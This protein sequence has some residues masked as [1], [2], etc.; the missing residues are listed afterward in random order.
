MK[1][2]VTL[3]SLIKAKNDLEMYIKIDQIK[4]L[5][6]LFDPTFDIKDLNSKIDRYENQL[7]IIK[8]AIAI[9]NAVNKDESGNTLYY[10]IY[11][12]SKYNRLKS[13]LLTLQT[14]LDTDQFIS[15][16]ED[17]KKNLLHEIEQLDIDIKKETDKKVKAGYLSTKSKLKRSLS[18][19]SLTSKTHT[20]KL[21]DI[22]SE[23]LKAVETIII[24]IKNTLSKNNDAVSI[25]VDIT[26]EFELV[27]K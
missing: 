27:V 21:R 17:L 24:Q 9:A 23:D 15:N 18:K 25:D 13:D 14:R 3:T 5:K 8:E 19:T 10:S 11:L 12:L 20:E 26:S 16:N 4:R 7:I 1:K 22:I 6:K 2:T